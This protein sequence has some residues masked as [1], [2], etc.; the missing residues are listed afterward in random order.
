MKRDRPQIAGVRPIVTATFGVGHG[1]TVVQR[2]PRVVRT[3]DQGIVQCGRYAFQ[4]NALGFC[5]PA[6]AGNLFELTHRAERRPGFEQLLARFETLYPY[7]T[8]LARVSGI[9]DTFDQ[10]VVEAYW[11]GR[12]LDRRVSA[13]AFHRHF[14]DSLN[15]RKR[16]P[17]ALLD[18]ITDQTHVSGQFNHTSHVL[19]AFTR[20]E[21]AAGGALLPTLDQCRISWGTVVDVQIGSAVVR[22]QP[23]VRNNNQYALGPAEAYDARFTWQG[24][25]LVAGLTRGDVVA[26]HWGWVCDTLNPVEAG[27]LKR[28]TVRA[29]ALR[30]VL[31]KQA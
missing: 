29:I 25:S 23:L 24:D 13:S 30:N 26:L 2:V 12:P 8:T 6:D 10:R 9:H 22:R 28:A 21:L 16:L 17:A 14:R 15:L 5:G 4:P 11:L 18:E 1:G 19:A 31:S 7:L 3:R 20:L 27:W